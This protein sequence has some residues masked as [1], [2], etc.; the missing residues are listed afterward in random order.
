MNTNLSLKR[1]VGF[2]LWLC[3]ISHLIAD[4]SLAAQF[5]VFRV[6]DGDTIKVRSSSGETTIILVG[7]DAPEVSHKKGEPGQPFSQQATKYLAGMVLNKRVDIPS[8]PVVA[9]KSEKAKLHYAFVY[10]EEDRVLY[11]CDLAAPT[12]KQFEEA[13]RFLDGLFYSQ[14]EAQNCDTWTECVTDY[15]QEV[16]RRAA[17]LGYTLRADQEKAFERMFTIGEGVDSGRIPREDGLA[18][19][20]EALYVYTTPRDASVKGE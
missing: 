1:L 3:V 4:I 13:T 16:R 19:I 8:V 6:T 14:L 12:S 9:Y 5:K 7:I 15:V 11:L 2:F 17:C 20:K 10:D 18:E